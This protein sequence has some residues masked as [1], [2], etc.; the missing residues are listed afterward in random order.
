MATREQIRKTILTAAGNP[1]TGVIVQWVDT[2]ADAIVAL[3]A[4]KVEQPKVEEPKRAIDTR[5]T[6]KVEP[7]EIR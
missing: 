4:P 2:F 7:K 6:R 1:S 3:D 5:E